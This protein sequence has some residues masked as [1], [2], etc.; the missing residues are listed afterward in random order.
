[1]MNSRFAMHG[2]GLF[3]ALVLLL[4][5]SN[6]SAQAEATAV[7]TGKVLDVE[8]RAVEG[9][10]V[11][12][13]DGQ[14]VRRPALF[15][16]PPA[17][18]DGAFR[19]VLVPGKY[20]MVAR[21]KK[22]EEY[23]PL[24]PGDKHSGEPVVT[25]LAAGQEVV[26]DFTVANMKEARKL[27]TSQQDRPVRISGR[28]IDEKGAPVKRA[29]A[30]ARKRETVGDIPEYLSA[31]A[32]ADGHY[33]LYLPRGEYFIGSAADVPPGTT[34]YIQGVITA[35]KDASGVDIRMKSGSSR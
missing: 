23:G 13:Y 8:G 26:M 24:M 7:F 9:A 30:I 35:D 25:D 4:A 11:Y 33:T 14:D 12:A 27:R 19:M 2:F 29:Y 1:M 18:G 16:S 3:S 5:L 21:L 31:W 10:R 32:D 17:A 22:S 34:Y 28:I 15:M 20:W 6:T